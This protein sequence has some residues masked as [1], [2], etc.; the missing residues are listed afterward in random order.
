MIQDLPVELVKAIMLYRRG[1]DQD[2]DPPLPKWEAP[3]TRERF[4]FFTNWIAKNQD[5]DSKEK[6]IILNSIKLSDFSG[7]ELLTVIKE[8]GLFSEKKI[9]KKCIKKFRKKCS[10]SCCK[11]SQPLRLL[12]KTDISDFSPDSYSI[13]YY[14]LL[15]FTLIRRLNICF[16]ITDLQLINWPPSRTPSD[17]HDVF[18]NCILGQEIYPTIFNQPP[19]R[20]HQ[21]SFDPPKEWQLK[22]CQDN[23]QRRH[24][25]CQQRHH[26]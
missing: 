23:S 4:D 25:V 5:C 19:W 1:E 26:V 21:Q 12:R 10:N 8:S 20:D 3:S 2:E 6:K 18:L 11:W 24:R 22:W 15:I 16:T 17:W 14:F 13:C 9:V 7:E